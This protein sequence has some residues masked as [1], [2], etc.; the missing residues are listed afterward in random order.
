MDEH[1]GAGSGASDPP[2]GTTVVTTADASETAKVPT[3][4]GTGAETEDRRLDIRAILEASW[5]RNEP[6]YRRL[7]E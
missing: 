5:A 3:P 1:N 6:G 4:A 7:A 2:V